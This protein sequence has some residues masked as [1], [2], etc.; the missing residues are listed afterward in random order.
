MN[1]A[2]RLNDEH[3]RRRARLAEARKLK[4]DVPV[5]RLTRPRRAL[6]WIVPWTDGTFPGQWVAFSELLGVSVATMRHI[7]AGRREMSADARARLIDAI[8]IRL[9]QGHAILAELEAYQPK[10]KKNPAVNLQAK[11][12]GRNEKLGKL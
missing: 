4:P 9:E 2:L 5:R 7:L 10:P 1:N 3:A 12:A 6:Q 8:K 11:A